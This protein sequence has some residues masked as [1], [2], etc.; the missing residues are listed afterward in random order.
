MSFTRS[1][2]TVA[3]SF[4]LSYQL[5]VL[6]CMPFPVSRASSLPSKRAQANVLVRHREEEI[7][8]RFREGVSEKEKETI[9]TTHG[10]RK[11]KQLK[12][13]SGFEKLELT[14]GRDAKTAVLQLLLNPQVQF[15][16]PNFLIEKEDV[17]PN[18]P[19]FE[20]QWALQN[21]GQDGGQFGSDIRARSAW[22]KTQAAP[23]SVIAVIDSGIDFTHPD[24]MN[25]QWT[26]PLPSAEGDLHG[27]DFVANKSEIKDEQGHGTA[28]AGIIAAE[29]N[30]GLGIT[31]VMWHAGLMS[32]R[33]LDNT[34][35]GD[36]ADAVE[37]IDYA[38]AHGAQVI[39]LSWGTTGESI[40]LKEAI[41]RAIKYNVVVVCSAGNSGQDLDTTPYYP[42][43]FGLKDLI[44]VGASDNRDQLASWSNW[45][46]R[47]V[48]VAAPGTNIL[49]TQQ[50]GGY[51]NVT[52]TSAA[53]P[54][55]SGIAGLLKTVSPAAN[56]AVISRAISKSARQNVSLSGKV[57][58]GGVADA[59]G[60]LERV[61]GNQS[62][63]FA[64]PGIG[65][66]GNGPGGGFSTTSPPL[67]RNAPFNLP[68]LDETRNAQYAQPK[69]HAPI[70]AN[71]PCADCD[72]YGGGGGGGN[73]P[74]GDPNFSGPRVHPRN[75]TGQPGVDLGSQNVNW[76]LPLVS[77]PGRAGLDLNLTLTYNSLVWTKD[78]SFI[79]FNSDMGNPAPGFRL[80]LPILQQR[81]LN[82]ST[83]IHA[84]MMVTSSGGRVELRQV[85]T[86]NIYESQDSGYTQL[87][88]S[89]PNSLLLRTKDGTRYKFVPVTINS[90]Y[91]C[92]EVKDRNG[93]YISAS[94]N[95][96][97]GHVAWIK[98]TLQRTLNF[99]YDA[100]GNL[101]TIRQTWTGNVSHDWATFSYGQV[102]VA[103]AFGGGLQINGP[104]NNYVT[105]L[106]RVSLHDGTYF[107]FDYNN[108]FGQVKR[109]NR[110]AADEH[111]LNYTSYNMNSSSGQTDCPK[112]TE[113]RHWAENWNGGNEAVTSY[114]TAGDNSWTQLTT[115]D[116]TIYKE[117]FHTSGWQ[118]GLTHTTE[119]WSGGVKKK[120][121][122]VSYTQD[123]TGLSYK[124]NPRVTET[125]VYDESGNRRRTVIEY[126]AA[127]AQWG[128]PYCIHEYAA[129][130]TTELKRT[131]Y[132]Y[133][134]SQAYLDRRIIGLVEA[135]HLTNVSSYQAKIIYAYDDPTR[136]VAVPTP[137]T[138]HDTAYDAS[139]TARGNVTS[140]SRWDVNDINNSTKKLTT[141]TNYYT[142]GTPISIT[143]PSGHTS[144]MLYADSFSN[145]SNQN[146]FA[147]PTTLK[148][149][150]NFESTIKY[151]YDFGA[152]TRTQDPKGA[153]Q[154]IT[155]DSATRVNRI[156]NE[157]SG[158][159]TQYVYAPVGSVAT[160]STI[161][162][163]A[164]EAY[165][166]TYFDGAGRVR[167][168]A[169]DHPGSSGGYAGSF[170]YYDVM[171]RIS[172]QTNPGELNDSW[173]ASGDDAAG[174]PSTLQTYDWKGRPVLTTSP[175]GSTRENT[176]GG[177]G[178]A[179]G[180]QITNRD[181]RGRRRRLYA[182]CVRA[183]EQ[184]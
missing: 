113:Q 170:I 8:V 117:F 36:V 12:G 166:I 115:P 34:G 167:A 2:T 175:G 168:T 21:S 109:I 123:D 172:E 97:N 54:I 25:N 49:T 39:N 116:G 59:V 73:Y 9:I 82:S 127:Y 183:A 104:N 157:T 129:D 57:S 146:T 94:Y 58:S 119:V 22:D 99:L 171:G 92:T 44:A 60:A 85:G 106:T 52:G 1:R 114:S 154:A 88:V 38:I 136:L 110:Y 182:R 42:A 84:Y 68:N 103:P 32:L 77:L 55:V 79:K 70:Q 51:W 159:Y 41:E 138:Q 93:N 143:D 6:L 165:Q 33:V 37:A 4:F 83:G 46:R 91:R 184:S 80:G 48:T 61:H 27:W 180:E 17:N 158:A 147:Y 19:K 173:V 108:L 98:D 10:G 178:C 95:T 5:I 63:P 163:G 149:A 64:P 151:N 86:S 15:A 45:G 69:A 145:V 124:K 134:L 144:G 112:F 150:D 100:N 102:W 152:V 107:T 30:N 43:S 35:T 181:E 13:D 155:Y 96:T 72:P 140:V 31:G 24:L 11:K 122:T 87:D 74:T 135:I 137:A 65:S 18:D 81:F 148:D 78:G 29:G 162:D 76:S 139:F 66:G 133:N 7:L 125:N 28:V 118:S 23:S 121:T 128:L 67:L 130:G 105:V 90:E 161:Q 62:P 40:A 3:V 14:P 156:T 177:C 131:Y 71:L 141:S 16:E 142:T 169:S 174:L 160:Y 132:D 120:W 153:V 126:T 111:L 179:G 89:D 164:G 53:A 47:K 176:Y 26:N 75:E 50:G 101:Q 56:P 20:E